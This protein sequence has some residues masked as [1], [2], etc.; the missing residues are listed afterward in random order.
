MYIYICIA[1]E[2]CAEVYVYAYVRGTGCV[3]RNTYAAIQLLMHLV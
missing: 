2:T 1:A 3:L